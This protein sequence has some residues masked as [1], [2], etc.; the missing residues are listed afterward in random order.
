M[1]ETE[2]IVSSAVPA[3]PSGL[4]ELTKPVRRAGQRPT[5]RWVGWFLILLPTLAAG[6]PLLGVGSFFAFRVA[7]AVLFVTAAWDWWRFQDRSR[8][9]WVVLGL[10]VAFQVAGVGSYF[11]SRPPLQPAVYELLAVGLM[12]GLAV[13]LVQLYRTSE[14]VLTV[15]RGWLYGAALVLVVNA[16]ELVTDRRLPNYYLPESKKDLDFEWG[17]I[18]GPFHNPNQLAAVLVMSAIVMA[19]GHSLEHDRRLRWAYVVVCV[20]MPYVVLHTGST[21][22][23]GLLGI[24]GIVWLSL[25]RWTRRIGIP[26]GIVAVFALPPGRAFLLNLVGQFQN[27][28]HASSEY[29]YSS[30]DRLNLMLNGVVMLRR[31]TWIGVGPDGYPYVMS[32]QTMPYFTHGIVNPHAALVEI[33]SQYGVG[34]F[35]AVVLTLIGLAKWALGRLRRTAGSEL[36]SPERAVALWTLIAVVIFPV[37]TMMNSTWLNQ[38]MSALWVGTLALWARHI[39]RPVGRR[40]RTSEAALRDL[41]PAPESASQMPTDTVGDMRDGS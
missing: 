25:H 19:V 15:A 4:K 21:L 41:P 1:A 32:T 30:G 7:V 11:W 24:V 18:A 8:T 29:L 38:S 17:Q 40:V 16:W 2:R 37:L 3:D 34:I 9:F 13:A 36:A 23:L 22:G 39:E 14:T 35:V 26:L 27:L 6:G 10:G 31:S 28:F 20:P 5:P 33:G 12:F